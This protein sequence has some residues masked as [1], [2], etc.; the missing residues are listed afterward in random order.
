[1]SFTWGIEAIMSLIPIHLYLDKICG[2]QQLRM[3]FLLSNHMVKALLDH[4]HSNAS[5]LYYFS[6]EKLS[7]KQK[8]KVKNSIVDINNHLNRILPS[9]NPLHKELIPGFQ[10]VDIFSN[11][12]SFNIVGH[13]VSDFK[14]VDS[15][16]FISVFHFFHF[17][18]FYI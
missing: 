8:L 14:M 15:K 12:F 3:A 7:S 17:H 18:F 6:L 11:C 5:H 9:F 16:Y 13:K 1:M 10:L 2:Y 4:Y